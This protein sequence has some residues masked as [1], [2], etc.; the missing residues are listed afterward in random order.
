MKIAVLIASRNR[1]DLVD[2]M[3][4]RIG[5][6]TGID[7]DIYVVE[8]GTDHDKLSP[9]SSV[10]YADTEFRGK[11]YGHNLALEAANLT[12]RYD[13]YWVLMNDVVFDDGVDAAA[14]LVD[15]LER[16]AR[17]AILSPTAK[18]G[19][20][21]G[22]ERRPA[23]ANQDNW[24][25]VTTC[26]YLG[27]MMRGSAL[28]EVG[29]LNADFTY[30]WGAIHE[31]AY[32][33]YRNDW[34]VAYSDDV[35]YE[36]LGGS[37][38]GV[39]GTGTISREEY[40]QNAKRFAY[41]YFR[42]NYGDN[43]EETFRA[44]CGEHSI[45]IDT[46]SKH[47][48]L[49]SRGFE[50]SE[51]AERQRS[52]TRAEEPLA[53]RMLARDSAAAIRLHLGCGPEYREGWINVDTNAESKADIVSDVKK[54]PVFTDSSVDVIEACHLFEHLTY[55]DAVAALD[56]WSRVLKPGGELFL[57]M[58]DLDACIRI[59]GEHAD[60]EGFDLGLIGLYGWPPAIKNEGVPQIHKW[61]WSRKA[62]SEA[63]R[64]V[65]FEAIEF[66]PITQTWRV[67]AKTGRDFRVRAVMGVGA[68]D[69]RSQPADS[70]TGAEP[71][72][73]RSGRPTPQPPR[74]RSISRGTL[75]PA[76]P[77]PSQAA[78]QAIE[79][80]IEPW[81]LRTDA[82]TRVFAWPRFDDPAELDHLFEHFGKPLVGRSDACL[83]LRRDP[84]I[85]GDAATVSE[86][87]RASHA[88]VLGAD[89]SLEI[90]VID[91][92]LLAADWQRLGRAVQLVAQLP[93][94]SS[95]PRSAALENLGVAS[96]VIQPQRQAQESG[97]EAVHEQ[98]ATI[99]PELEEKINQLHPWFYPVQFG[100]FAVEPGVGTHLEPEFL[101]ERTAARSTLLIEKVCES[102]QFDGRSVL[103]LACNCAFWSSHYA[104]SG[105]QRVVGVEGREQYRKQ[106][107]LWW[108]HNKFLPQGQFEFM[109]GNI[110]D[111]ATWPKIRAMGPFDVTLC[112][113]I[114][115]HVPNYREVL[116][117]ASEMTREVL[118]VDTRVGDIDE[119]T[120][121]EPGDLHFNAI[122]ATLSKVVPNIDKLL[123]TLHG[124][125][126][127]TEVLPVGFQAGLGVNDVDSYA[128]GRRVTIIARKVAV[129]QTL[130]STASSS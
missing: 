20:Y 87:L 19:Q 45:E 2:D 85:D 104:R 108:S 33:L 48:E 13:Y 126:M 65:G 24:R 118:I 1:P 83:C 90:L 31:L 124:L 95:A 91:E 49:W 123:A 10:W 50:A 28:R 119:P 101:V 61:G 18:D 97:A 57:E 11:C 86:A 130:L 6:A 82:E 106:A 80:P 62:L 111:A 77:L 29:F 5:R 129:P 32:K 115:Y 98:V 35:E 109:Q 74:T 67:A 36:H 79:Q 47:K 44:A 23:T 88:R 92:S 70:G 116:A 58:P 7:H 128:D 30:C 52:A 99:T 21:P 56:E 14:I 72:Q 117:W 76:A 127:Q 107:E 46:F 16:N 39:A 25:A 78:H 69:V 51:L 103:D 105:A 60:K 53:K 93:S 15:T 22:S 38:Y 96:T 114:L 102:V 73:Q 122:D 66:G 54:L 125:G 40:Q 110:A 3:V 100:E 59:M 63:L 42:E 9:H 8:C 27:F 94:S 41:D 43:W 68:K 34:F 84:S 81:P 121:E 71:A 64:K 37:T 120:I 26:D 89:A 112:A 12:Q 4:A 17:M 55:Y 75:E 113:G